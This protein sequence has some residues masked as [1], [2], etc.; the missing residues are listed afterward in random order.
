M[1]AAELSS[2]LLEDIDSDWGMVRGVDDLQAKAADSLAPMAS[3]HSVS[4][5]GVSCRA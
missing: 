5:P 1:E 2:A 3:G 4:A